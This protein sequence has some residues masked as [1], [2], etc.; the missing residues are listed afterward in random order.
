MA[1]RPRAAISARAWVAAVGQRPTD[2]PSAASATPNRWR[3]VWAISSGEGAAVSTGKPGIDLHG[4]AM[5]AAA[6]RA[7]RLQGEAD[8][9]AGEW[10]ATEGSR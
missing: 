4:T 8:L 5:I 3:G 10:P 9:A 1:G 7:Q 2:Q 6:A